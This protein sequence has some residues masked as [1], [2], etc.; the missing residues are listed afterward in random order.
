[1]RLL[2]Q[3]FPDSEF[4]AV[5]GQGLR[6]LPVDEFLQ[7]LNGVSTFVHCPPSRPVTN[8]HGRDPP[9]SANSLWQKVGELAARG[10]SICLLA[11]PGWAGARLSQSVT[12]LEQVLLTSAANTEVATRITTSTWKES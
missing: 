1:M 6:V 12:K 2:L 11:N 9:T 4:I 8:S 7:R 5:L 3:S 10:K